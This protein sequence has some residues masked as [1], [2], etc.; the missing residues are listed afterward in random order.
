VEGA[1]AAE[2]G[3]G[4]QVDVTGQ[5]LAAIVRDIA[6]GG[7]A[8]LIVGILIGGIGGRLVMRLATLLVPSAT[9]QFTENGFRIGDITV[10]GT[11]G[12]VFFA[13]LLGTI[14]VGT[15]W[16]VMAPWLPGRG[17]VRG[18]V[19][20][21]IAVVLGSFA[22]ITAGNPDFVILRHDPL[23]VASLL[24]LVGSTA[25]VA[26]LADGWLD[27]RLPRAAAL[28]TPAGL[29]YLALAVIGALV[30]GLPFVR[31]AITPGESQPLALTVVLVGLVTLAWW[32]E[33][34]GG[35]E[36]PS[37]RLRVIAWAVL[38]GGVAFGAIQLLPALR[39][40]LD[41]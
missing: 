22:L 18:L 12:L 2:T 21:P 23:V 17:I 10:G 41:A 1:V 39:G 14:A 29:G 4:T 11:L 7:L 6:R 26:A 8:G 3:T 5:R 27:R 15:S 9:G 25:P 37:T 38:A 35:R 16:V 30:G 28:A 24:V 40:A 13:S 33:R 36:V 20:A 34:L 19:A 31:G 32:R